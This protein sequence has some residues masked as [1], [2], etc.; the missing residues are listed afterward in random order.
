MPA[1][2]LCTITEEARELGQRLIEGDIYFQ[3]PL[4]EQKIIEFER[5]HF[6]R[7][8][9]DYR[10]V[11]SQ[12]GNG[13]C[14]SG[15]LLP[16]SYV[17]YEYPVPYN[18]LLKNLSEPFPLTENLIFDEV[19]DG[20][21]EEFLDS[22]NHGHLVLASDDYLTHWILI[23]EGPSRGEVWR[24][25]SDFGFTRWVAKME[26]FNWLEARLEILKSRIEESSEEDSDMDMDTDEDSD[27]EWE[28]VKDDL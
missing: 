12:I 19:E 1:L 3:L 24:R 15:G 6:I 18:D 25:K 5:E 21:S 13:T 20:L 4:S 26:F 9:E 22:L 10:T 7:L 2:T 11:L 23:V 8:P 14:P 28:D 17:P 27:C 16:L